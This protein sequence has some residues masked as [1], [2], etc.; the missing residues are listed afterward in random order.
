MKEIIENNFL[1]LAYEVIKYNTVEEFLSTAKPFFDKAHQLNFTKKYIDLNTNE[2]VC[3]GNITTLKCKNKFEKHF[4]NFKDFYY[5]VKNVELKPSNQE[6][7]E[8]LTQEFKRWS[9][10]PYNKNRVTINDYLQAD[11]IS[12]EWL[13]KFK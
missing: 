7:A 12:Q 1:T 3:F 9:N 10:L 4:K 8:L 5:K 13:N 2:F 6:T 11:N